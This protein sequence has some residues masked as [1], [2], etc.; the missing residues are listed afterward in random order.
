MRELLKN[1]F[2]DLKGISEGQLAKPLQALVKLV[3]TT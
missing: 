1:I 2:E 3:A